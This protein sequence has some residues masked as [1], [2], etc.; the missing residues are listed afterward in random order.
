MDSTVFVV[1]RTAGSGLSEGRVL[2]L[3]PASVPVDGVVL[4]ALGLDVAAGCVDEP[5]AGVGEAGAPVQAVIM[6]I[7][8]ASINAP[9]ASRM[10][11]VDAGA[12]R[13]GFGVVPLRIT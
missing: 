11:V 6:M 13:S 3:G 12:A 4:L 5:P 1:A 9:P 10:L 8:E 7:A 2:A